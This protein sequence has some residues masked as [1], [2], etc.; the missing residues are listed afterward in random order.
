MS[1]ISAAADKG[2]IEGRFD[3]D[4]AT[5]RVDGDLAILWTSW[6]SFDAGKQTHV[7][8]IIFVLAKGKEDEKWTIVSCADN[9]VAVG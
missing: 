9:M 2:D 1:Y 5:I 3:P 4:E 8:S 7:G 6:R